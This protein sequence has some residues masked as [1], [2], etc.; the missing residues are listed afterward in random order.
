MT[1]VTPLRAIAPADVIR[2]VIV[3]DHDLVRRGLK[4]V[5]AEHRGVAVVGEAATA[6]A[7]VQVVLERRPDLLL[8]DL[9]LG[10]E[11]GMEVARRL[12][13][14]QVRPRV[15]VLSVDDTS[16]HLHAALAAG[17]DGYLLKTVRGQELV[18]GIRACMRGETVIDPGFVPK[19]LAD[20]V[21]GTPANLLPLTPRER[22]VLE[23]V[24]DG[25]TNREVAEALGISPRTAQKHIENLFKKVQASDRTELV[26]K[27]LRLGIIG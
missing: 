19:L 7:A 24:A 6:A 18:D 5:L 15:L 14:L 2:V 27:S 10:D 1:T 8:L 20:A 13:E 16:R 17:A 12:R 3:D 23:L 9:R 21:T 22:Q 4:D 26:A 25:H 11:E